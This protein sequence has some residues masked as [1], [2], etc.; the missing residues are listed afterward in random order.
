MLAGISACV[1]QGKTVISYLRA[2]VKRIAAEKENPPE[3]EKMD[4][5]FW[6][7]DQ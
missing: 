3:P 6:G 4:D 7:W 1:D 2:C 5:G